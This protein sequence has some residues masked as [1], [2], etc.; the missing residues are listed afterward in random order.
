VQDLVAIKFY[1][2]R[3]RYEN[4]KTI[5]GNE[6]I[7]EQIG[8]F[9]TFV[10]NADGAV[11]SPSGFVFPPYSI[12][13]QGQP[14]EAWLQTFRADFVTG[15]QACSLF[16]QDHAIKCAHVSVCLRVARDVASGCSIQKTVSILCLE[17]R[18]FCMHVLSFLAFLARAGTG[19]SSRE[20]VACMAQGLCRR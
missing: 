7:V 6:S 16:V 19:I 10:D 18:D 4:E 20:C 1:T 2:R 11:R 5:Y 9:P 13:D 12:S 17:N 14:L 3:E 15:M 8:V